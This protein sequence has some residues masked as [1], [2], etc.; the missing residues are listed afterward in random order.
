M[1]MAPKYLEF[2]REFGRGKRP[3]SVNLLL[4][5]RD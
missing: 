4:R 5:R 1:G 3:A 2:R